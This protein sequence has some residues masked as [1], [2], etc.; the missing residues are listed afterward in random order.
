MMLVRS[1]RHTAGTA[2]PKTADMA[3]RTRYVAS[4]YDM[5]GALVLAVNALLSSWGALHC[6]TTKQF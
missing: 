5:M 3:L 1:V 4:F 6:L 2:E